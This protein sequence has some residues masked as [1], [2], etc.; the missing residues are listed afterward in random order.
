MVLESHP[1][2]NGESKTHHAGGGFETPKE[3]KRRRRRERRPERDRSQER[4]HA[5]LE[6]LTIWVRSDPNRLQH[7]DEPRKEKPEEQKAHIHESRDQKAETK[8]TEKKQPNKHPEETAIVKEPKKELEP[9]A[10]AL[11]PDPRMEGAIPAPAVP[12]PERQKPEPKQQAAEDM[13]AFQELPRLDIRPRHFYTEPEVRQPHTTETEHDIL[14]AAQPEGSKAEPP[15]QPDTEKQPAPQPAPKSETLP[16]TGAQLQELAERNARRAAELLEKNQEAP[17]LPAP[18]KAP[19]PAELNEHVRAI[20]GERYEADIQMGRDEL[21]EVGDS[22][23]IEGVSVS[24]MYRGERI[25]DEGLRRIIV[26]FL[27]GQRIEKIISEEVL[28]QQMRF[29]RDP[30]LRQLPVTSAQDGA[31]RSQAAASAK[32]RKAFN[33]QNMR[34]QADR[35]A[36]RLAGGIDR[37]VETAENNPNAF[38][39]IGGI[40]AVIVYFV[41]LILIIRS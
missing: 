1:A 6:P 39:T 38:K 12:K 24:E 30:Q 25:D 8:K 21:L 14:P 27:R 10:A 5:P 41:I 33:T 29:E 19:Q 36:D 17:E 40:L 15:K 28:R 11:A 16:Q 13:P 18:Q 26:E 23:R 7:P 35:I 20:S 34:R 9:P 3:T 37:A 2:F 4:A 22:I 32:Q 31:T